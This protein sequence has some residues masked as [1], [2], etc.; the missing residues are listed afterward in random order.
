MSGLGNDYGHE[1]REP[2]LSLS[3]NQR[4][5]SHKSFLNANWTVL[6]V[7]SRE[8][9]WKGGRG[10]VVVQEEDI[11]GYATSQNKGLRLLYATKDSR[12]IRE[13]S[14]HFEAKEWDWLDSYD[15][16]QAIIVVIVREGGGTSSYLIGGRPPPSQAYASEQPGQG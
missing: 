10:V 15:P 14:I 1:F 4:I 9:F 11:I 2:D 8:Q 16:D 5:A 7:F 13:V 3:K 6:S 12:L